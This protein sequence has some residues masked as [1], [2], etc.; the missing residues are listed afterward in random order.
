[1][2]DFLFYQL[3]DQCRICLSLQAAHALSDEKSVDLFIACLVL[4]NHCFML[5]QDRLYDLR[6]FLPTTDVI[7]LDPY[8]VPEKPLRTVTDFM[9]GGRDK[10]F[11]VC[12]NWS[13]P[14]A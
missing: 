1:M 4:R 14:T 11:G 6:G 8:P 7:G 9:R 12:A 5:V 2:R 13:V 10:M 3:V